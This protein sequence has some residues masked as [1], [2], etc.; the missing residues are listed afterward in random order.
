MNIYI[1]VEKVRTYI[2]INTLTEISVPSIILFQEYNKVRER[3]QLLFRTKLEIK[4][5][6][7]IEKLMIVVPG[8]IN[9][10]ENKVIKSDLLDSFTLDS[11]YDGLDFNVIFDGLISTDKIF[12]VSEV[13]SFATGIAQSYENLNSSICLSI[14]HKVETA[15]IN[16]NGVSIVLP[17]NNSY[18]PA[19]DTTIERAIGNYG[20]NEILSCNNTNIFEEYSIRVIEV[21]KHI[22]QKYEQY[23]PPVKNV[24]LFGEINDYLDEKMIVGYFKT[25]KTTFIKKNL[26]FNSII[27][28]G[29]LHYA[30]SPHIKSIAKSLLIGGSVV[31]PL[32]V[33]MLYGLKK[34][35]KAYEKEQESE[36]INKAK[37][38]NSIV[39]VE[40]FVNNKSQKILT[41]FESWKMHFISAKP[42]VNKSNYYILNYEDA[43]KIQLSFSDLED[44]FELNEYLFI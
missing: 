32:L 43:T 14:N 17:W 38:K 31:F 5:Y 6:L 37:T 3:F 21:L 7:S 25:V 41:D 15:V 1:K 33:P 30:N 26:N 29:V 39:S 18:I 28:Q 11:T 19:L 23:N 20:I 16:N 9:S 12:V 24:I 42:I 13:N 44:V 27:F 2:K 40:Y 22:I 36:I 35:K 34:L 4:D 10:L 8:K